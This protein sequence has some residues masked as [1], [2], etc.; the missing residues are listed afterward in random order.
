MG[1]IDDYAE[2]AAALGNELAQRKLRLIYG[3]AHV[4]LM[5][6]LADAV[7]EA[8]GE[9]VGVIPGSLVEKEVAHEGLTELEVTQSMHE[10]KTRMAELADAFI[11]LPGGA[12]TLEELFEVWT[13]GQL[14]FHDKPCGMLNVAGYFNRLMQFLQHMVSESFVRQGHIDMLIVEE[15]PGRLLDR[16]GS[17]EPPDVLKWL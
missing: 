6:V 2:V 15:N 17:Y 13:W 1:R 7:L 14:Q 4:G 12:G 5:G 16:F 10:R 9:V 3:G 8:G 11:A